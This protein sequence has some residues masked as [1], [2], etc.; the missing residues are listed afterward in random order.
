MM[1]DS[2]KKRS[3]SF[4]RE[5]LLLVSMTFMKVSNNAKHGTDKKADK[6]WDD[7]HLHYNKLVGTSN[8]I[9]ERSVEHIPME[10]CNT[11]SLSNCWQ[12]R[13][14]PAVQKFAGIVSRS[15][16]LSG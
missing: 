2:D 11:E 4:T 14:A 1:D 15:K 9:N 3:L 16:P 10:Q 5:E 6:F 7:I 13:L 8:K 12:R